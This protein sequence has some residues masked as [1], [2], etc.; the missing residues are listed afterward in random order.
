MAIPGSSLAAAQQS[1]W[2]SLLTRLEEMGF[3]DRE[4][5]ARVL[6]QSSGDV[7]AAVQVLLSM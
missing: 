3:T 6:A 5:N 1:A 2:E 7:V 4:L